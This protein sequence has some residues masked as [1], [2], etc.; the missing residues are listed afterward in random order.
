MAQLFPQTLTGLASQWFLSLNISKRRTW[1]DI[2]AAFNS[3]YS[4]NAQLKM[5]TRE[6]ESIKMHAKESFVDFIKRWKSKAALMTDR[7]CEKDQ[8]RISSCN[9]L[10]DFAKNLVLVQGANFETFFDSGLA[11]DEAL[12]TGVLPRTGS[13]SS[14]SAVGRYSRTKQI[15]GP[16]TWYVEPLFKW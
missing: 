13:S 16:S 6:L 15:E 3:Q 12:Q 2:G 14:T 1:E 11:I 9:L 4:Y 8:I 5:T 10:P 7:P